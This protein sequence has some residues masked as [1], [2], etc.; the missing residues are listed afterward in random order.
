VSSVPW[1]WV[2]LV[3][4]GLVAFGFVSFTFPGRRNIAFDV[5]VLY[6]GA[7]G[8]VAAVNATRG[9]SPDVH[10]STLAD[11][12]AD[13]LDVLP[14]RPAE[15]E[16]VEREVYL[17]IGS[18]FY[19]HHRLRPVLREIA[20]NQLLL[21]HGLDFDKRPEEARVLLGETAWSWLRPDRPEPRDRWAPGPP[22][23]EL[24]TVV[25]ALERI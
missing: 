17:S 10:E 1:R 24:T 4:I 19:L 18:W 13:P 22:I 23:T 5:F 3:V 2:G 25:D 21:R 15:L 7:L 16:R 8:L 6:V 11:A 12:L 14:Q 20:A 9:A